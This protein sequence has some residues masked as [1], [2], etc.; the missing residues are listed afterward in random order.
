MMRQ[1]N[2]PGHACPIGYPTQTDRQSE[3]E[4]LGSID[5]SSRPTLQ[6][7]DRMLDVKRAF[8]QSSTRRPITPSLMTPPTSRYLLP[9]GLMTWE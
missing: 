6:E 5:R 9:S 4:R 7:R 2:L 3:C 8:Y 1:I